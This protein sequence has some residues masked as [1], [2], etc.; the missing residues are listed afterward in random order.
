M[1]RVGEATDRVHHRENKAHYC[2]SGI[3]SQYSVSSQLTDVW[4][5]T[6]GR[7]VSAVGSQW[8]FSDHPVAGQVQL[9]GKG[10]FYGRL[11]VMGAW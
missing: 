3:P 9:P 5:H 8:A 6:S 7:H 4:S 11:G 1:G 2:P 10:T